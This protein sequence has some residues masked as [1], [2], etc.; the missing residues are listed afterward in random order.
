MTQ[1]SVLVCALLV[2]CSASPPGTPARP[3]P[4]APAGAGPAEA[5]PPGM[6]TTRAAEVFSARQSLTLALPDRPAWHTDDTGRWFTAQH[7]ATGT[8]LWARAWREHRSV[9]PDEC[10]DAARRWLPE[11]FPALESEAVES[12]PMS[13]P[14]GYRGTLTLGARARGRAVEGLAYV[15]GRDV[16]RCFAAAV[17]T[18]ATGV[19]AERAVA[20]RLAVLTD[21][22]L[23]S[24]RVLG[25]EE[26]VRPSER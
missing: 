24:A 17:R 8:R 4:R 15:A 23:G 12:R 3:D 10:L 18:E 5:T 16:G 20:E 21:L 11:A 19:A 2:A 22:A 1:A 6:P 25:A 13:A 14:P 7:A 9:T 26:R